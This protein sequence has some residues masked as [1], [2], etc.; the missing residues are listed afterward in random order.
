MRAI[1]NR[2][3][4]FSYFHGRNADITLIITF[5]LDEG[6]RKIYLTTLKGYCRTC[7][8]TVSSVIYNIITILEQ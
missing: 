2:I 6:N 1:G 3:D 4:V 5:V 7:L 8:A